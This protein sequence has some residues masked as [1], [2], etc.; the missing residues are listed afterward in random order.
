MSKEEVPTEQQDWSPSADQEDPPELLHI[1]EEQ[2]ELLTSQ[3]RGQLQ[4]LEETNLIEFTFTPEPMKDE[5]DEEKPQCSQLHQGQTE[6]AGVASH[7]KRQ[8]D[9][10]ECGEPGPAWNFSPESHFPTHERMSH[11]E[12]EAEGRWYYEKT[13]ELPSGSTCPQNNEVPVSYEECNAGETSVHPAE[14]SADFSRKGPNHNVNPFSCSVYGNFSCSVCK[15]VFLWKTNLYRHMRIH[16]GEK[17]YS[18][19][20]CAKRFNQSSD[21]T[22]HF[23]IHTGEKPFTCSVCNVSFSLRNNLSRHMRTHATEKP[24]SCS[25]CGKGFTRNSML[26]S[27]FR[28]HT[29]EKPFSCSVCGETFVDGANLR[30]HLQDH[31]EKQLLCT[32]CGEPFTSFASLK[33]HKCVGETSRSEGSG[34][35]T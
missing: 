2:E 14:R 1:K 8:A 19:S 35:D 10:E 17:P 26:L 9:G 15:K 22:S 6:E 31:A 11:S 16:T 33:R 23:R 12:P 5:D 30:Q 13:R 24:H 32:A 4:G 25:V 29:G 28:T 21:L 27:H 3:D 7:G 18:C 20:V 34:K